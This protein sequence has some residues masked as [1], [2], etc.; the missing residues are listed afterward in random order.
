MKTR[1]IVQ[2]VRWLA[3]AGSLASIGLLLAFL[4][5]EGRPPITCKTVLFPFGVMVGLLVAWR[6]ERTGGMIAVA[7]LL[8]F[9]ALEQV[10]GGAF[11]KGSAFWLISAPGALFLISGCMRANP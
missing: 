8:V 9:Y 5:G 6:F 2:V 1:G 11:P 3:R 10:G 4:V 7:C